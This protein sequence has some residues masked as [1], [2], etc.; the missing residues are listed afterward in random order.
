MDLLI[1]FQVET[2]SDMKMRYLGSSF[3]GH[4]AAKDLSSQFKEM[5]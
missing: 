3:F 5:T 2:D 1:R 4:T